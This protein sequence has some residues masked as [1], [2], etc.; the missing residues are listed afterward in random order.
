MKLTIAERIALLNVLPPQGNVVTLRIISS[1]QKE[2]SF[3]EEEIQCYKIITEKSTEGIA[4]TWD[5]DYASE[6]KDIEIGE[7]LHGII[8]KQLKELDVQSKLVLGMLPLY[9]KFVESKS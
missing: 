6:T 4:I 7:T 9:E 5:E 8:V 3:S 1:L 2:L